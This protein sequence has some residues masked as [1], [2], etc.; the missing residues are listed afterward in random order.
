VRQVVEVDESGD[1]GLPSK[2]GGMGYKG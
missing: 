2:C 1:L